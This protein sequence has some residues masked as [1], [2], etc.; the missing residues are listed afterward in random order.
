MTSSD[1][2]S[3][4]SEFVAQDRSIV[5]VFS[6]SEEDEDSSYESESEE[7]SRSPVR[8][9]PRAQ[10]KRRIHHQASSSES[11]DEEE[12]LRNETAQITL[13]VDKSLLRELFAS[14]QVQP[15]V[16]PAIKKAKKN[17]KEKAM[18]ALKRRQKEKRQ[19]K[20]RRDTKTKEAPPRH[21]KA[22]KQQTKKKAKEVV[23]PPRNLRLRQTPRRF[24]D[25]HYSEEESDAEDL[26]RFRG[27]STYQMLLPLLDDM[28]ASPQNR[29]LLRASGNEN[30]RGLAYLWKTATFFKKVR[31]FVLEWCWRCGLESNKETLTP[32]KLAGLIAQAGSEEN[33]IPRITDLG[34]INLVDACWACRGTRKLGKV[35]HW[36]KQPGDRLLGVDCAAKIEAALGFV[37][38]LRQLILA[39]RSTPNE[40][41]WP[42][43]QKALLDSCVQMKETQE[44][45]FNKYA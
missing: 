23:L 20:P 33:Q 25:E 3:M 1:D 14:I 26:E 10:Q 29:A 2:D 5:E 45:F 4:D 42:E 37:S 9:R 28:M 19:T 34:Q 31:E 35:L 17:A 27:E 40:R 15:A 11:D 13:T 16:E 36:S 18:A 22:T 32:T 21:K 43:E 38:A 8:R 6:S 24:S 44:R 39:A 30:E 7:R 41:E 12:P